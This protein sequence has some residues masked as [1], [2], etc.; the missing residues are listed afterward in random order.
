MAI[1][2]Y[3]IMNMYTVMHRKI[4]SKHGRN[5]NTGSVSAKRSFS[6]SANFTPTL[7]GLVSPKC[8]DECSKIKEMVKVGVWNLQY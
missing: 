6:L 8:W 2:K 1:I 5:L 7:Q 3:K 4:V